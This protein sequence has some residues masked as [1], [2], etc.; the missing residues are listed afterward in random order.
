MTTG[1]AVAHSGT[2]TDK[3]AG[4]EQAE[5]RKIVA[6]LRCVRHKCDVSPPCHDE[7]H[8][9]RDAPGC[10]ARAGK[11]HAVEY[12]ADARDA[13][14]EPQQQGRREP[15]HHAAGKGGHPGC[16]CTTPGWLS[17]SRIT[18]PRPIA[19]GA[20]IFVLRYAAAVR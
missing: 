1:A 18:M 10:I 8:D 19:T 9:K 4:R 13:T 14:V 12:S 2:E 5:A 17:G 16:H 11:Q 7:P 3:H 15:D 6:R 20:P